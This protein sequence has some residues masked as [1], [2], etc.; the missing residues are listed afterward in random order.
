MPSDTRLQ[1]IVD[2]VPELVA[3]VDSEERYRFNNYAYE[4]WFGR[5]RSEVYGRT[6]REILG[7]EAYVIALPHV[8]AALDGQLVTFEQSLVYPDG[9]ARHVKA[10]YAPDARDDGSLSDGWESATLTDAVSVQG[11]K[12]TD[13]R[14]LRGSAGSRKVPDSKI[15]KAT[16]DVVAQ[17]NLSASSSRTS[18]PSSL[19]ASVDHLLLATH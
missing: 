8:R 3:Y 13:P 19:L 9:K 16:T 5:P 2:A 7:E 14:G 18:S 17:D 12:K 4:Q 11:K 6:V 15:K 1:F 10:T